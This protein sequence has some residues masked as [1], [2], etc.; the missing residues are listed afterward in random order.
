MQQDE[1]YGLV[2]ERS[3][4]DTTDRTETATEAVLE[5]LGEA[6][7]GGEAEDVARQLPSGPAGALERADHDGAGYDREAF[8][9]R[10]AERIRGTDLENEE[11]DRYVQGVTDALVATLSQSELDDLKSQ[12]DESTIPLFEN[13]DVDRD[14]V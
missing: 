9:E 14:A 4:L 13:V 2:Q 7:T 8:G 12:L 6:L 3:Q 5:T 10:V 1:F 11:V